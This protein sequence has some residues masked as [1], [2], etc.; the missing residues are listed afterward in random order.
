MTKYYNTWA[1]SVLQGSSQ[2]V[3]ILI[4]CLLDNCLYVNEHTMHNETQWMLTDFFKGETGLRQLPSGPEP[5]RLWL[6]GSYK[7]HAVM[8]N[9]H[10]SI[11]I[12]MP[13]SYCCLHKF[14]AFVLETL[15]DSVWKIHFGVKSLHCC[16]PGMAEQQ[17][18]AIFCESEI[19]FTVIVFLRRLGDCPGL[20][21]DP[22]GR[23]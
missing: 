23:R 6:V 15:G 4:W 20:T 10:W 18:I 21:G 9:L 17:N 19:V 14:F 22:G 7:K 8:K 2:G 12:Y 11:A 16:W 5:L 1:A 13:L 3:S